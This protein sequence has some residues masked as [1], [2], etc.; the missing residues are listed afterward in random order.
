MTGE[1]AL[2][3]KVGERVLILHSQAN[4]DTRP[5]LIGGHGDYVWAPASSP[6]R[7]NSIRKPG[8]FQEVQQGAAFYTF[9]QPGIYAYV[10]HNLIEAFEKG[11]A[12]HFKVKREWNN[13]LMTAL[14]SPNTH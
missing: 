13:D 5:H 2:K 12:A 14:V 3:A 8:S 9:H 7:R 6:I 10:N 4:R 11:A 1:N